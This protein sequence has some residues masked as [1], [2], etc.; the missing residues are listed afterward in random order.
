MDDHERCVVTLSTQNGTAREYAVA[1]HGPFAVVEFAEGWGVV[2][3]P[4]GHLL[5]CKV[6]DG[7]QKAYPTREEAEARIT[8]LL[9]RP[10]NWRD[11]DIEVVATAHE[12]WKESRP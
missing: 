11:P 3:R 12:A 9:S 5:T 4:S 1:I 2:H 6:A 10:I 7:V 8:T